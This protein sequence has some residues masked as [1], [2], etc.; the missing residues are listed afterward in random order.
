MTKHTRVW[1]PLRY[2]D[3]EKW[4]GIGILVW[5]PKERS[6]YAAYLDALGVLR[7]WLQGN[8]PDDVIEG[9]T[10]WRRMPKGPVRR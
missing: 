4:A 8:G 5:V 2:I 10:Q 1:K 6:I 9:A 7:A 3:H